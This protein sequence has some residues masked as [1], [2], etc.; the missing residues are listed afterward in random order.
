MCVLDAS[1]F[2]RGDLVHVTVRTEW[3][4]WR[5]PGRV[6]G[7][8]EKPEYTSARYLFEEYGARGLMRFG[9]TLDEPD[10]SNRFNVRVTLNRCYETITIWRYRLFPVGMPIFDDF[11]AEDVELEVHDPGWDAF[12]VRPYADAEVNRACGRYLSG[13][14]YQSDDLVWVWEDGGWRAAT[15]VAVDRWISVRYLKN[16]ANRRGDR[17]KSYRTWQVWPV[18]SEFSAVFDADIR[19]SARVNRPRR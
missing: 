9:I 2:K 3:N 8:A 17:A 14:Y 4:S 7:L 12:A 10:A 5:V 6:I 18:A 11:P 15:V 16:F 1:Y 13:A 19:R